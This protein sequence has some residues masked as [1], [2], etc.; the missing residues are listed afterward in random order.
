M[1]NSDVKKETHY[2]YKLNKKSLA[3]PLDTRVIWRQAD[4]YEHVSVDPNDT[5]GMTDDPKLKPSELDNA[6]DAISENGWISPMEYYTTNQNI[7]ANDSRSVSNGYIQKK[8][9]GS[10]SKFLYKNLYWWCEDLRNWCVYNIT[11]NIPY[12]NKFQLMVWNGKDDWVP[13]NGFA[14]PNTYEFAKLQNTFLEIKKHNEQSTISTHRGKDSRFN[15]HYTPSG[16]LTV[17]EGLILTKTNKYSI[18][19]T[20]S[21][22]TKRWSTPQHISDNLE[23]FAMEYLINTKAN[24]NLRF[25]LKFRHAINGGLEVITDE[26]WSTSQDSFYTDT[27]SFNVYTSDDNERRKQF[28]LKYTDS[29]DWDQDDEDLGPGNKETTDIDEATCREKAAKGFTIYRKEHNA[30]KWYNGNYVDEQ[31]RGVHFLHAVDNTVDQKIRNFEK[32]YKITGDEKARK[33]EINNKKYDEDIIYPIDFYLQKYNHA[34]IRTIAWEKMFALYLV[35]DENRFYSTNFTKDTFD[36]LYKDKTEKAWLPELDDET[37]LDY[38][39]IIFE[40]DG[41]KVYPIYVSILDLLFLFKGLDFNEM[42]DYGWGF[43]NPGHENPATYLK[44]WENGHS[45]E[46]KEKIWYNRSK[47]TL[48]KIYA[49]INQVDQIGKSVTFDKKTMKYTITNRDGFKDWINKSKDVRYPTDDEIKIFYSVDEKN[50]GILYMDR[51]GGLSQQK[52]TDNIWKGWGDTALT[53]EHARDTYT[54][55]YNNENIDTEMLGTNWENRFERMVGHDVPVVG[56]VINYLGTAFG[57]Y[58]NGLISVGTNIYGAVEHDIAAV[59]HFGTGAKEF[60]RGLF[61]LDVGEMWSGLKNYGEAFGHLGAALGNGVFA[62]VDFGKS[63]YSGIVSWFSGGSK[64]NC[65]L[66]KD[67]RQFKAT[68]KVEGTKYVVDS[69]STHND[70][71]DTD[72]FKQKNTEILENIIAGT[73]D[74]RERMDNIF[75]YGGLQTVFNNKN[76]INEKTSVLR[77]GISTGNPAVWRMATGEIMLSTYLIWGG[78]ERLIGGPDMYSSDPETGES[79]ISETGNYIGEKYINKIC[80]DWFGNGTD[81]TI[82]EHWLKHDTRDPDEKASSTASINEIYL[83]SGKVFEQTSINIS[84]TELNN[85]KSKLTLKLTAFRPNIVTTTDVNNTDI[86]KKW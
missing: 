76:T 51:F 27:T 62:V 40:E 36:E 66:S 41:T 86:A 25:I 69:S 68:L 67:Y 20:N 56:G 10:H 58:V 50:A 3:A 84:D 81:K 32:Y 73:K 85:L 65:D 11:C 17:N 75:A 21:F 26:N 13:I 70:G 55:L 19:D 37:S 14:V 38:K 34:Q 24:G 48:Q 53:L 60:V 82:D 79:W 57:G 33:D 80:Q 46:F 72:A 43:R 49:T 31:D 23:H 35:D 30:Y 6:N 2:E 77:E 39:D 71:G 63:I 59:K 78:K 83:E 45:R 44:M 54:S 74:S 5:T 28:L 15:L 9:D 4:L 8:D 42:Q 12:V 16:P 52:N 29:V 1:A 61:T 22:Q 47:V 18:N 64:D 7:E